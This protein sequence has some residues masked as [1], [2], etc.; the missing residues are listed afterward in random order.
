MQRAKI[1][2]HFYALFRFFSG[3]LFIRLVGRYAAER[4]RAKTAQRQQ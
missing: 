2:L 3:L 1:Q 4:V